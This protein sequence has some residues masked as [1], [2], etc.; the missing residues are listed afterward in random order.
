MIRTATLHDIPALVSVENRCFDTDRLSR[1]N[2]RYM[3]TKANAVI[4]ADEAEGVIRG[5]VLV[6]FHSGTSLARLYSIAVTPE[7]R[8]HGIGASLMKA[9]EQSA[10]DHD[11]VEMRLEVRR[12]NA[13][14]IHLYQKMGYRQFGTYLDYHEDHM[15]ALRFEKRLVPRLEPEVVSVPFYQ[16]TLDFTCG[17]A[18]LMMGMKALD[19]ELTLNRQL[20]LR[21]WREST[22]VFMTSGH[23]A[24]AA[25]TSKSTSMTKVRCLS[26]PCVAPKKKR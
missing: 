13:P 1:R 16:Q 24:T 8:G 17:P 4:L 5:Y 21:I 14:S 25:S 3:I 6:L 11:C 20:E 7:F 18:A 22:T 26:I 9:A 23:G 2:F 12:D 15:E 10:L 19:R